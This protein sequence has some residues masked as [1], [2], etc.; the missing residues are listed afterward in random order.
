MGPRLGVDRCWEV[1]GCNLTRL[2]RSSRM[3]RL[4][5]FLN[6]CRVTSGAPD[7]RLKRETRRCRVQRGR[8]RD[9]RRTLSWLLLCTIGIQTCSERRHNRP[10]ICWA[11]GRLVSLSLSDAPK[12]LKTLNMT[13]NLPSHP[14][15]PTSSRSRGPDY[16]RPP[17]TAHDNNAH[18]DD[19]QKVHHEPFPCRLVCRAYI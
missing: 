13:Y 16:Q 10:S 19:A 7:L 5:S 12:K 11:P 2:D 4:L 9:R 3:S 17:P 18:N 8:K 14:D 6:S 15:Y 1:R